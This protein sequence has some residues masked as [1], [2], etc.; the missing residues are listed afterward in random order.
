[1]EEE[2]FAGFSLKA[3]ISD[4]RKAKISGT[5]HS[6]L[7]DHSTAVS[8]RLFWVRHGKTALTLTSKV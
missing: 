8:K 2:T 1:M 6:D 5:H 7:T 3:L 4:S